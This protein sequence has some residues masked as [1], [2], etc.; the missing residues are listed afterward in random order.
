MKPK[1]LLDTNIC[2]YI[3][4][5]HPEHVVDRMI[6]CRIGDVVMSS[7]TYA[8]LAYGVLCAEDSAEAGAQLEL[9][10]KA[11]PVVSFDQKAAAAFGPI[12]YADRERKKDLMDKLIAAHAVGLDVTVVTNNI[13]DFSVYPG[14]RVE[15]WVAA[16]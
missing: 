15:N 13:S 16:N 5:R 4:R 11:V 8:E 6:Q 2:I 7:I 3:M 10:V 9:L 12:R 14:I 1:Y